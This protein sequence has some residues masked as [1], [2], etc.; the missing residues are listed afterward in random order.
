VQPYIGLPERHRG[1]HAQPFDVFISKKSEDFPLAKE[2]F[3]FLCSRELR[4]FLSEESL[5]QMGSADYMKAIDSAL[6]QAKHLVVVGSRVENLLAGWVEAEW[7]VFVNEKRSGRKTGNV[8]TVVS[9]GLTP[10]RLPMSLRYYE[11]VT[12]TRDGLDRLARYV[13][14]G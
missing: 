7:R 14:Q 1:G 9:G 2:V 12:L 5:P 3:E 6:E 4:V 10:E 11:V 8:V 13:D